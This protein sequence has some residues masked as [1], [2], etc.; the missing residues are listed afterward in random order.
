[1]ILLIH[2]KTENSK[3]RKVTCVLKGDLGNLITHC[4]VINLPKSPFPEKK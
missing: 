2:G 3:D 4:S 1:M